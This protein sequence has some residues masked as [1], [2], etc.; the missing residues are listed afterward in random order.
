MTGL[1][2]EKIFENLP[3]SEKIENHEEKKKKS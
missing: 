3:N 2:E 1:I